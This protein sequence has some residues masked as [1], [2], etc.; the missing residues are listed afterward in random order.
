MELK[1]SMLCYFITPHSY[2]TFIQA[3]IVWMRQTVTQFVHQ[4]LCWFCFRMPFAVCHEQYTIYTGH[5]HGNSSK[6]DSHE[7]RER[8]SIKQS[9]NKLQTKQESEQQLNLQVTFMQFI[10]ITTIFYSRVKGACMHVYCIYK[11]MVT[12]VSLFSGLSCSFVRFVSHFLHL[13]VHE[14]VRDCVC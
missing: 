1:V 9:P 14:C 7:S 6:D 4:L 12:F 8:T 10:T 13:C 2:N 5:P 3:F 11:Y